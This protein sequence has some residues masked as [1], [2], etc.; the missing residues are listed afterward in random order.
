VRRCVFFHLP[1]M[2]TS[3]SMLSNARRRGV[4]LT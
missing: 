1:S 4:G 2:L 3:A